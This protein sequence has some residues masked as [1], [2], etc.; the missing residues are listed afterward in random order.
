MVA[1]IV[2]ESSL[3]DS[4]M[5]S[6]PLDFEVALHESLLE[7]PWSFGVE[8]ANG[9]GFVAMMRHTVR[10]H[11]QDASGPASNTVMKL[12]V[13][14]D[15]ADPSLDQGRCCVRNAWAFVKSSRSLTCNTGTIHTFREEECH[16]CRKEAERPFVDR[17]HGTTSISFQVAQRGLQKENLWVWLPP[18]RPSAA[19]D[20]GGCPS[21]SD[22]V[23]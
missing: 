11:Q 14:K 17:D 9:F 8:G 4:T 20:G 12:S 3:A 7:Q 13:K 1:E 22:G 16:N 10:D 21:A 15:T 5:I 19:Q 6:T 23:S 18:L 2:I